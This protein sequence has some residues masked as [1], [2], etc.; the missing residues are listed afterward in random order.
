MGLPHRTASSRC[1]LTQKVLAVATP[2]PPAAV[3]ATTDKITLQSYLT[4]RSQTTLRSMDMDSAWPHR[5]VHPQRP[6]QARSRHRP[7][8]H[9]PK[10]PAPR[11]GNTLCQ[12]PRSPRHARRAQVRTCGHNTA[13]RLP[14]QMLTQPLAFLRQLAVECHPRWT[15]TGT[16]LL[17]PP[18]R[19]CLRRCGRDLMRRRSEGRS[20]HACWRHSTPRHASPTAPRTSA[21]PTGITPTAT[22]TNLRSRR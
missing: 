1:R 13:L 20:A 19:T 2:G 6:P 4:I 5:P 21:P 3:G 9:L 16:S 8:P 22:P 14:Q 15:W 7:A 17:P 18:T 10:T 12:L 11:P